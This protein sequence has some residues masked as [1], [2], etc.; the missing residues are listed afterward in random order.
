LNLL[1]GT[2]LTTA[3]LIPSSGVKA[4]DVISSLVPALLLLTANSA[5]APPE[6]AL[7]L[8]EVVVHV[9]LMLDP[10][11]ASGSILSK[12]MIVTTPQPL[13]MLDFLVSKVSEDLLVPSASLVPSTPR[14]LDPKPLT[15]SSQ[16][17]VDLEAVPSLP[18]ALEASQLSAARLVVSA[19]PV[20]LVLS[21]APTLL[22]TALLM[23]LRPVLV[24]AW[25]E[26]LVKMV[27]VFVPAGPVRIVP[28]LHHNK[29][30]RRK[31]ELRCIHLHN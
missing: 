26:V 5:P 27:S 12:T 31:V 23:E 10:T 3:M 19:F 22:N 8:E 17:A 24:V 7:E 28:L 11:T 4:K 20:M 25:V 1:V 14:V 18:L 13:L 2:F 16:H 9:P 15:A 30:E 29:V 6:L 21:T